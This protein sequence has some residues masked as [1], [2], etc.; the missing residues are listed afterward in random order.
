MPEISRFYG[1]IISM[2]YNEHLP[3]HFHAKYA[4]FEA[5]IGIDA[6]AVLKGS[7]PPR[8]LGLVMEWA[9][10]RQKELKADWEKALQQKPL[11]KIEPLK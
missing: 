6:L 7:L 8:A 11:E 5:V 9:A 4:E 1:I 2:F 3:A 10:F